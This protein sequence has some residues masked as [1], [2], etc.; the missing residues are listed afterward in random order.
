MQLGG[1]G[2]LYDLYYDGSDP[3]NYL[4][5]VTDYSLYNSLNQVKT[6]QYPP[7]QS[8]DPRPEVNVDYTTYGNLNYFLDPEGNE[9][10]LSY[11]SSGN[12]TGIES[13]GDSLVDITY[14][15]DQ[16]NY[17]V[18]ITDNRAGAVVDLEYDS[19]GNLSAHKDPMTPQNVTS[20]E[21]NGFNKVKKVTDPGGNIIW[22]YYDVMGNLTS[23]SDGNQK[24]TSYEYNYRG[25]ITQITDALNNITQF[26]YGTGCPSCGT[27][28]EK[29]TSVTDARGKTTI[30]QY[31]LAGRLIRETDPLG[32]YKTYS[33]DIAANRITKTDEDAAVIQ[34]TYD[35]L[36]RLSQI[37]Y[38]G[39][40]T[41]TFGYD[42]RSN[43]KTA[44][45]PNIGYTFTHDLNDRLT[46]VV[47]SNNKTVTYQYNSL[48]QRTQMVTPD[49]RTITYGYDTGNRLGQITSSSLVFNRAYDLAG[50]RTTLSY[51][52]GVSTSYAY[53]EASFLTGLVAQDSQQTTINSFTYTPDGM[54]NRTSMTDLAGQ[55][56]YTYDNTYQL[57]Q[58]TH[59][60]MPTEQFGY[61]AVGSRTSSGEPTPGLSTTLYAYDFENRL[62]DV[63]F[64]DMVVHYKYDPFGRRIEKNVDGTI[65][66]YVYDGPNIV[67]QYDGDWNVQGKYL[68]TLDIDDPLMVQQGENVYYYHKD[69]LGSVVNLT[70]SSQSIVK[71]YTYKSFGD[72]YSETGSVV[73]PFTFTGREYDAESGLY[74]YRARYYDPRA[75]R[76]LTKD[77]IGFLGGDVNLYRYVWNS[78]TNWIDPFGLSP[79]GWIVKLSKTSQKVIKGYSQKLKQLR[80]E[81]EVK[82]SAP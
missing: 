12:L 18:S 60:N 62:T 50:R 74:Y 75:G 37:S 45:N 8:G 66:K 51:P 25:Q 43:L 34:Y 21:Y 26:A 9:F 80:Q 71:G 63:S 5:N 41:A 11:D 40:S 46:D 2:L 77:P 81:S 78:S 54:G 72:I 29:L 64:S 58:A 76:F 53:N 69:G 67:T 33:Y 35:D 47:D 82:M 27:G 3:A 73:Q 48:N 23:T 22:F 30:F 14:A 28:V 24:S 4:N 16:S 61:D 44:A 42:N 31:D 70:D 38:P 49:G 39:S 57:T 79:I 13:I 10:S 1:E 59:P 56:S 68:F 32:Q 19:A 6:I 55:H 7:R 20:L 17:L 65:T 15:Y 52:N 36:N